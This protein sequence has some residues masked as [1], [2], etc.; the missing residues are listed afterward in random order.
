[1]LLWSNLGRFERQGG[2]IDHLKLR[3]LWGLINAG[4]GKLD[5]AARDFAMEREGL[6]AAGLAYT[7]A[8]AGLDLAAVH[9][10]RGSV[11]EAEAVALE[12]LAV[13]QEMDIPDQGRI[14]LLLL[15]KA[16]RLRLAAVDLLGLLRRTAKFF[17]RIEHDST[18]VFNP[19]G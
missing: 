5:E 16:L 6:Q 2:Q 17:R 12:S 19:K 14:A 18:A 9:L 15:E 10:E 3:G 8:I 1:M 13:F 11:A 4:L 7:A